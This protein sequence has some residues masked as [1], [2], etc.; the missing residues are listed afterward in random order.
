MSD[1]LHYDAMYHIRQCECIARLLAIDPDEALNAYVCM[2]RDE[3]ERFYDA[4]CESEFG[5]R[6][7]L[8]EWIRMAASDD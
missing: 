1:I 5:S 8:V 6:R 3:F 7:W 4:V 2:E